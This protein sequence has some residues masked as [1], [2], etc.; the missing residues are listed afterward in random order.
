VAI[1]EDILV[2]LRVQGQQQFATAVGGAADQTEKLGS[3]AQTAAKHVDDTGKKA[4]AAAGKMSAFTGSVNKMA[5]LAAVAA[6]GKVTKD[7]IGNAV[8][9]GEQVNKNATVFR[10]PGAKSVQEWS[11]GTAKALGISQAS[12]LEATGT[13]GNMLVP[14]GIGR[15]KAAD[16]SKSMVG[17]AGDMASFNNASP[18]ETLQAMTSGLSG[19]TE[20]LRK[21]GVFLSDVGVKAEGMKTGLV[22]ATKDTDKIK[23]SQLGAEVAQRKYSDAVKK[24]GK[25]S[26]QAK[27]A[28]AGQIRAEGA[29]KKVMHGKVP[30]LTAAQKA[31]ATYS[32]I[33]K[34]SK[35][36]QGDFAKTSDSLANKQRILRAE[37]DNATAALG[38]KLLPVL[39][40]LAKNLPEVAIVV[41]VIA[42]AWVAW[43][44]GAAIAAAS[45][46]GLTGAVSALGAAILANPIGLIAVALIAVVAAIVILYRKCTWFRNAV[47]AVWAGV[48]AGAQAAFHGVVAAFGW[49]KNAATNAVN[50]VKRAFGNVVGFFKGLPGKIRGAASGL[51]DG[52]KEGFRSALNAIIGWWN[53]F[54]LEVNIPDAIPGLPDSFK[55]ETPNLPTFAAG[56]VMPYTGAALVGERGPELVTLPAGAT[57]HPNGGGVIHTHVYLNGRE[58]ASAVGT[59]VADQRARR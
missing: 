11:K 8:D 5:G 35:D 44:V 26:A 53:S 17:L 34:Q 33:Q 52:I 3:K 54:S 19:E 40:T 7:A 1:T 32:L 2:R 47:N 36:A 56:G 15:T 45:T 38:T 23:A 20:P 28:L 22:K 14:M 21:F 18:E 58:I 37:Y 31:Q 27:S 25:N 59:A 51:W 9:L 30:D 49:I 55:I 50:W 41:G 39:T 24:H 13:L 6:A 12:A 29:L 10:G 16:M 57:V 43:S 42:L 48:K 4:K 46:G